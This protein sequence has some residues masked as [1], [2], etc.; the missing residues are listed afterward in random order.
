MEQ[1]HVIRR[2]KFDLTMQPKQESFI[3]PPRPGQRNWLITRT[4]EE[5]GDDLDHLDAI[6]KRF[7][8]GA[9]RPELVADWVGAVATCTGSELII[10]DQQVMHEWQRDYMKAIATAVAQSHG[11]VLEI[12]FGMGISASYIQAL[13]VASHTI[14]ECNRDIV[15]HIHRWAEGRD[16]ILI[17]PKRWQDAEEDLGMYDG[18]L[19]DTYPMTEDEFN[20]NVIDDVTYARQFF[21]TASRH[22]RRGGTFSYFSNEIDSVSRRHQRAIF[23]HFSSAT[24]SVCR[25]IAPPPEC[26]IWW[27]NSIVVAAAI[28]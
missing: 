24:F 20:R 11:H 15:Q 27:A 10:S 1:P 14:V 3:S 7:V 4:L 26:Q 16:N 2:A 9:N 8:P 23:E 28:K 22:L 17:I 5:C 19:F 12:G 25:S 13:G 6:A 21:A 18:I